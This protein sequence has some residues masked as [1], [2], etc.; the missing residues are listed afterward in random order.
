MRIW[1]DMLPGPSSPYDLAPVDATLRTQMEVGSPRSRRLT[2][3]RRDMVDSTWKMT[4]AEFELFRDWFDDAARSL[5]GDSDNLTG[6]TVSNAAVVANDIVGPD[7]VLA[8]LV[9]ENTATSQHFISRDLDGAVADDAVV[10]ATATLRAAGRAAGRLMLVC[11]NATTAAASID[12]ST[13]AISNLSGGASAVALSRGA[14]WWRVQLTAPI[15]AGLTTPGLA[16]ILGQAP[17]T[18]TYLGDGS[19]GIHACEVMAR[20]A[21]GFDMFGRTGADGR[22]TGAAGG[23]AWTLMPL[24][25]GGTLKISQARFEGPFKASALPG[26]GWRVSARLEVK[27]A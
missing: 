20:V 21:T 2:R 5:T 16:I 25:F 7:D 10:T 8:D 23:S 9:R 18:T 3:A 15:G 26:L 22:M 11:K 1:P 17:G 24:T 4:K 14:G 27:D 19:S 6:W 12:L 13:G